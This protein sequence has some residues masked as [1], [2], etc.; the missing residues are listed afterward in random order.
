[1]TQTLTQLFVK[2]SLQKKIF[3]SIS[4]VLK[5]QLSVLFYEECFFFLPQSKNKWKL[6]SSGSQEDNVGDSFY[7]NNSPVQ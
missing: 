7:T 3:G 4:H 1:M 5:P 2:T 6:K